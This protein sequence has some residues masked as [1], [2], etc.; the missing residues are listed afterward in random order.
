MT[1]LLQNAA[2]YAGDAAQVRIA[3]YPAS[4]GTVHVSIADNG[5]G[6]PAERLPTIFEP[7]QRAD[8]TGKKGLGL[9]LALARQIA[10]L[11]GGALWAES[12]RGAGT[13]FHIRLP[14]GGVRPP[15]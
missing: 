5:P 12:N 7:F 13:V 4:G 8:G 6:I 2:K 10:V 14:T 9:G 3:L 1:N 11:H 15:S